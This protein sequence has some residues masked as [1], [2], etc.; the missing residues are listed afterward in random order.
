MDPKVLYFRL[1][2]LADGNAIKAA[3]GVTISDVLS[4]A[5]GDPTVALN[6]LVVAG[7]VTKQHPDP[8]TE[9]HRVSLEETFGR[10]PQTLYRVSFAP[11]DDARLET[12]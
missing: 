11:W 2:Q 4:V 9:F 1:K 5:V 7:F 8:K 3:L 6:R 10:V 12:P